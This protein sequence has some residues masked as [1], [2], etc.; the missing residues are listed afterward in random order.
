VNPQFHSCSGDFDV[1]VLDLLIPEPAPHLMDCVLIFRASIG[2]SKPAASSSPGPNPTL[3][4][5]DFTLAQWTAR[6]ESSVI[7]LSNSYGS[8][9]RK[10]IPSNYGEFDFATRMV[11]L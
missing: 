11:A 1:N 7:R 2:S 9:L 8:I 5:V 6:R 4:F 3:S 10:T